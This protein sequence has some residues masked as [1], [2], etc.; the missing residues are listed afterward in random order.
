MRDQ[1]TFL[2][3]LRKNLGTTGAA[4]P[5]SSFLARRITSEVNPGRNG[6]LRCLEVGAG[7]GA[8]TQAIIKKLDADDELDICEISPQFASFLRER[9]VQPGNRKDTWPKVRVMQDC[10]LR[11]EPEGQ[12]D[13]IISGLPFNC[14]EPEFVASVFERY[15]RLLKPGGS[16]SYFEYLFIRRIASPFSTRE[17]RRRLRAVETVVQHYIERCQF[18]R[19]T[20]LLNIPPAIVRHLRFS[21][22]VPSLCVGNA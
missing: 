5:S 13:F 18:K 3:V 10:V 2:N 15:S 20:V 9:F 22:P 17:F 16:M 11:W 21:G 6:P 1:V 14:F 19:E 4:L 12:Y 8:F 7:T